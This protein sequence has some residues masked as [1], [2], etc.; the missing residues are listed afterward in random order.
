MAKENQT[1]KK[2]TNPVL[3]VL[4]AII[5]PLIIVI[6]LIGVVL[7]VAGFNVIDWAKEKGSDIP[8]VSSFVSTEEDTNIEF[9]TDLM[10]LRFYFS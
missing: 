6:I 1:N 3:W 5:I 4:F 10:F 8:V 7:G 2:K 9:I